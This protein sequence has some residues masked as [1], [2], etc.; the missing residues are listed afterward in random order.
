[1][2]EFRGV[3]FGYG[4]AP[5]L[6]DISF[7]IAAGEFFGIIGPNAS[8]KTS[9][10]KLMLG[11][12]RPNQGRIR[13]LGKPPAEALSRVGYVPQHPSFARNIPFSVL[14]LV[15]VGRLGTGRTVG[16]FS[17]KDRDLASRVLEEMEI[18]H[19]AGRRV[20]TLSGGELQRVLIARALVCEPALLILD[21][22][23]ANID[24][25]AEQDVFALL[26]SHSR[27]MTIVIVSHDVSFI[28]SYV[29]RVGCVNRTLICHATEALTGAQI[30]ELY[31]TDVRMI[32][33]AH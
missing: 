17:G 3:N 27:R 18:S 2:V 26:R 32:R 31:G 20:H 24:I 4:A 6:T 8:G 19:L 21:E 10:L 11:L 22:P 1:V 15:L 5:L 33:H 9:L 29:D 14:E 16:A 7:T 30:S 12:L 13:V 25:S 28:S 23:T